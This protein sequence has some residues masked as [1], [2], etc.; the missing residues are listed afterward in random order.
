MAVAGLGVI[1][2]TSLHRDQDLN[3]QKCC[4]E[5]LLTLD[6][7]PGGMCGMLWVLNIVGSFGGCVDKGYDILG[8]KDLRKLHVKRFKTN[9]VQL[10]N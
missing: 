9:W 6:G 1:S 8:H 3:H 2:N 10:N 4:K 5:Q 7:D